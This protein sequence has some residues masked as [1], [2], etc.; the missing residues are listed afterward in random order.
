[1]AD[2][3]DFESVLWFADGKEGDIYAEMPR[4]AAERL[5]HTEHLEVTQAYDGRDFK[6]DIWQL[7]PAEVTVT[8]QYTDPDGVTEFHLVNPLA[9]SIPAAI[10]KNG[11]IVWQ[12][13]LE[14]C[15]L[16][17]IKL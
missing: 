1:M 15:E 9:A 4:R 13:V 3:G 6:R 14:P 8:A 10:R 7:E 5:W 11:G 12:D 17:I 2:W 16:K